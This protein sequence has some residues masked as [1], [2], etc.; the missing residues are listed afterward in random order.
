MYHG[1]LDCHVCTGDIYNVTVVSTTGNIEKDLHLSAVLNHVLVQWKKEFPAAVK[2]KRGN[3]YVAFCLGEQLS[4]DDPS[5]PRSAA[6]PLGTGP[7]QINVA[8]SVRRP[9]MQNRF[10]DY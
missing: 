5:I 7:N 10:Y 6:G 9:F 1:R 3:Q 2:T 4:H 8:L